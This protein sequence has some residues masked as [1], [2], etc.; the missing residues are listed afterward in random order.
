MSQ[1]SGPKARAWLF[2]VAAILSETVG[3]LSLR[4]AV[5]AHAMYVLVAVGFL[6]AFTFLALVLRS[7]ISVGVAYGIWG[8]CGVA[9]TAVMAMILFGE[10]LTGIMIIGIAAIFAGVLCIELGS[11]MKPRKEVSAS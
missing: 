2:L 9:L 7:G 3:S 5:D 10:P 6:S 1:E 4:A 8:A 11:H